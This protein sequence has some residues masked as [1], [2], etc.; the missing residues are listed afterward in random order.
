[1]VYQTDIPLTSLGLLRLLVDI[2]ALL[3]RKHI[4]QE[5]QASGARLKSGMNIGFSYIH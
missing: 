2:F 4:T 1:M 5:L 3:W